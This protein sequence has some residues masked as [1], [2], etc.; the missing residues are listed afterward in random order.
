[1]TTK[2]QQVST[3]KC[4]KNAKNYF[5]EKCNFVCSKNSNF[6]QHLLTAK[7]KMTTKSTVVATEKMPNSQ[8]SCEKCGK[9]YKERTGLWR[10]KKKCTL[11]NN[12]QSQESTDNKNVQNAK[13]AENKNVQNVQ[14]AENKN[15][16]NPKLDPEEM[17][18]LLMQNRELMK[19]I[20]KRDEVIEKKDELME[21]MI[22][23]I[24]TTNNTTNNTQNNHFNVNV[25]LNEQCKD[26]INFSEFIDRIEVSHEDLENN[27]ELGFVNGISKILMD[28]LNQLNINERPIHCTDVK[29]ETMYI[30]D[31]NEW[32]KEKETNMQKLNDAIQEV[33]RKSMMSLMDWKKINPD[34]KDGDS[35]FSN[36]CI[37][38]H[39]QSIA[40]TK[41]DQY[42]PKV[43]HKIAKESAIDKSAQFTGK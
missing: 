31:D 22:D 40:I 38:M 27:A 32:Q 33:S 17:K 18:E 6:Q 9:C 26:A 24:G 42:Y 11:K 14:N 1:M 43:V 16:Q 8:F 7:H 37:A 4:Q 5:C 12:S 28:N 13:N 15:V 25:F 39:Q 30:K 20:S 29:R 23:K 41:K 34:Y 36:K 21:K 2:N 3:E 19:E 35:E 10:H